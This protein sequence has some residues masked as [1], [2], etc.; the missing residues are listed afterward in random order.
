MR[1]GIGGTV[2]LT[3]DVDYKGKL[4]NIKIKHGLGYGC[5]EEAIRLI[6][7]MK[8]TS[9]KNR[10]TGYVRFHAETMEHLF[11]KS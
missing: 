2:S 8:Y 11:P 3:F 5:E 7:L 4:S 9:T 10:W 1:H 6:K